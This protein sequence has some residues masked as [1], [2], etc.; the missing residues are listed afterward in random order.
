MLIPKYLSFNNYT[1][2]TATRPIALKSTRPI[3][4]TSYELRTPD[5][6][7]GDLVSSATGPS[8]SAGSTVPTIIAAAATSHTADSSTAA[9]LSA[10]T[11]TA[12]V[13]LLPPAQLPSPPAEAELWGAAATLP[14]LH[15]CMPL[16][17][18]TEPMV[19]GAA[20]K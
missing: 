5:G 18:A 9:D 15:D 20:S 4:C 17:S 12:P 14:T 13:Q 3:A 2:D 6:R 16:P 8:F 1:D 19:P 10:V 11:T 7:E